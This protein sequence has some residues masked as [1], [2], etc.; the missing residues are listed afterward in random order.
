MPTE[1]HDAGFEAKIAFIRKVIYPNLRPLGAM[2]GMKVGW[3]VVVEVHSD[4]DTEKP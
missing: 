1:R 2:L 3:F 4:S